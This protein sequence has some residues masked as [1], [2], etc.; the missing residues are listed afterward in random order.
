MLVWIYGGAWMMGADFPYEH[1][2]LVK[3]SVRNGEPIIVVT[4]N[5]R[6]GAYG[7]LSG[8]AMQE[9]ADAGNVDLNVGLHDQ[10]TAL[11]WIKRNIHLFG[12]DSDRITL[13]GE[14]AGGQSISYHLLS[15]HGEEKDEQLFHQAIIQSGGSAMAIT[16][17]SSPRHE[18]HYKNLLSFTP[19]SRHQTSLAQIE[20]LRALPPAALSAANVRTMMYVIGIASQANWKTPVFFPFWPT[21]DNDF[22]TRSPYELWMEGKYKDVPM[23]FGNVVSKARGSV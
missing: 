18:H 17:A 22:I 13:A 14:S 2:N 8:K 1:T 15:Q 6:V 19:C 3:Q 21:L 23:I 4:F 11:R 5:Y 12:G 7:F 16:R 20:C 10:R 9:Q